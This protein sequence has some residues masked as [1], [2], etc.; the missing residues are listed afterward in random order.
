MYQVKKTMSVHMTGDFQYDTRVSYCI[1][2]F[3]NIISKLSPFKHIAGSD[4][5]N[6]HCY[7]EMEMSKK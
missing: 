2:H 3:Q 5:H 1:E 4:A 6:L 7:E